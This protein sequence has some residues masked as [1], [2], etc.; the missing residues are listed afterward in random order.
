MDQVSISNVHKNSKTLD[1]YLGCCSFKFEFT[2]DGVKFSNFI[3][4]SD[5]KVCIDVR[6]EQFV[7][8]SFDHNSVNYKLTKI[9]ICE[10]TYSCVGADLDGS[11]V[12]LLDLT[13]IKYIH[14]GYL[15]Q[16]LKNI[17]FN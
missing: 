16:C 10:A 11:I 1:Q 15:D 2:E 12:G 17:I 3:M 14:V 6:G 5:I 7:L 4:S 8:V 13:N 9:S